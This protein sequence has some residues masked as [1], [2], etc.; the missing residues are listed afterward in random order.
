METQKTGDLTFDKALKKRAWIKLT[1]KFN[2]LSSGTRTPTQLQ[3]KW[4]KL[5]REGKTNNFFVKTRGSTN[6]NAG[7]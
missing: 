5:I 6:P 1:E 3:N 4:G 7:M 2:I